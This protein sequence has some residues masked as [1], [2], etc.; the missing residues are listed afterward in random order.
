[1]L[2]ACKS[3]VAIICVLALNACQTTDSSMRDAGHNDAYVIGFHDGR[4]TGME[5]AGNTWEHYTRDHE[6]F[7]S[8][9]QYQAGWIAGEI[10]GRRVQEQARAVGEAVGGT[11]TGYRVGE[12]A[13]KAGVHPHKIANDVMKDVDTSELKVLEK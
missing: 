6:R 9:E 1:M 2:Q 13:N 7:D 3:I 8:D 12:E 10:E 5:E 4:H 11:Y